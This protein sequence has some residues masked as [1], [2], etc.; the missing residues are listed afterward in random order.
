MPGVNT[1]SPINTRAR[2]LRGQTGFWLLS[3]L[4]DI[5]LRG[6]EPGGGVS[7]P[8]GRA[9]QPVYCEGALLGEQGGNGLE[10]LGSVLMIRANKQDCALNRG[11]PGRDRSRLAMG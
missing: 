5:A 11:Q 4:Q 2:I 8:G 1:Q 3:M 10:Q 6:C 9:A 7:R